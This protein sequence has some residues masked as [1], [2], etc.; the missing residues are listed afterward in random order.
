MKNKCPN[1][2][3]KYGLKPLASRKYG[4]DEEW[5][6]GRGVLP[7][8]PKCG[9]AL[10]VNTHKYEKYFIY[11]LVVLVVII[12]VA[13]WFIKELWVVWLGV[14]MFGLIVLG[15]LGVKHTLLAEWERWV[16][17]STKRSKNG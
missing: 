14:A 15:W 5:P 6:S 9:V 13:M 11:I 16:V 3:A 7:A 1:C 12:M 2:K 8:C 4:P 10:L 17:A